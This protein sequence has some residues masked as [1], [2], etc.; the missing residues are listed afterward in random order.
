MTVANIDPRKASTYFNSNIFSPKTFIDAQKDSGTTQKTCDLIAASLKFSGYFVGLDSA[1]KNCSAICGHVGDGI[2]VLGLPSL[3]YKFFDGKPK[4]KLQTA[5][6]VF[7]LTAAGCG[8]LKLAH[9]ISLCDLNNI[10]SGVASGV[11]IALAPLGIACKVFGITTK[12][13]EIKNSKN[14]LQDLAALK[15]AVESVKSGA[16]VEDAK[17]AYQAS[18]ESKSKETPK[19]LAAKVNEFAEGMFFAKA[20]A[21]TEDAA[22]RQKLI[23]RKIDVVN[24]HIDNTNAKKSSNYIGIIADVIKVTASVLGLI[25]LILG[26]ALFPPLMIAGLSLG[27]VAATIGVYRACFDAAVIKEAPKFA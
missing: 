3:V 19:Q 22:L 14:E 5:S 2:N 7:N 1:G 18:L 10:G 8:T 27:L 11:G 15:T 20:N 9:D 13:V 17:A 24:A 21:T 12:A 6:N 26:A 4:T 25:A 23:Q 16:S